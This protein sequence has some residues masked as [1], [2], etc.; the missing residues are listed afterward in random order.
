MISGE[1]WLPLTW[2]FKRVSWLLVEPVVVFEVHSTAE[3]EE[4]I[5]E[6]F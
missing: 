4:G 2:L 6:C 3:L 1:W 5:M